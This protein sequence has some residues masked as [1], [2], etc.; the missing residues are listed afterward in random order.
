MFNVQFRSYGLNTKDYELE[1]YLKQ[2][3]DLKNDSNSL[4]VFR[5]N[6]IDEIILVSKIPLA[7]TTPE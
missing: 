3:I 2:F 4:I 6:I 1:P 5:I 7:S